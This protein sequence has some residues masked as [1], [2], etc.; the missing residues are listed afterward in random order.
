MEA[1]DTTGAGDVFHGAF[2]FARWSGYDLKESVV[3][4]SA[5]AA[6]K[7]TKIGGQS[8]IPTFEEVKKFLALRLPGGAGWLK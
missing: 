1:V 4:A 3:L 2:A 7:C 5:V 6:V 8:G